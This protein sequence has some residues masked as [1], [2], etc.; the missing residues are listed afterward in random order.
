MQEFQL[1]VHVRMLRR[2]RTAIQFMRIILFFF[3]IDFVLI[4]TSVYIGCCHMGVDVSTCMF[5]K[6]RVKDGFDIAKSWMYIDDFVY[7]YRE[8]F[9]LSM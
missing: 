5:C 6:I 1:C 7:N 3:C 9:R 4:F 2:E 8:L